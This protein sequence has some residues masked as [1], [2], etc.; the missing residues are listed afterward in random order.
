[1]KDRGTRDRV[2]FGRRDFLKAG[3]GTAALLAMPNVRRASAQAA[4]NRFGVI[5][6]HT[7]WLPEPYLKAM[8]ELGRPINTPNPYNVDLAR[9]LKRMDEQGVQMHVLTV[10]QPAVHWAPPAEGVRLAQILNDTA[11]EAHVAYP[12]RFIA[13]IAMP[14]QDPAAAL[15]ELNRVAG[16]PGMC[17]VHLPTSNEAKDFLFKPDF[18]PIFARAAELGYPLVFHPIGPVAGEERIQGPEFFVNTIGFPLEH[19]ITAARFIT[20]GVLDKYP[21]LEILLTHAGGQFPFLAG[22]I[23][24]GLERRNIKLPRPFAEYIRR[25]HYDTIT[26]YPKTLRFLIDLVGSDRVV[27]GT[28]N[29]AFMDVARPMALVEEL[30]LSAGDRERILTT[31]AVK[32]FRL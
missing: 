30:N 18:E 15:K 27:I 4:A 21:T 24:A 7:H 28:D 1:M 29:Y 12:D 5:D 14:I 23:E 8:R 19:T 26:F 20:T 3:A 13:G 10:L 11:I 22:R 32:L 16:K 9:R 6:T 2:K 25:F 17:A 31:N